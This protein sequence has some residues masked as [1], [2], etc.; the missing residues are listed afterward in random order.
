V[1]AAPRAAAARRAACQRLDAPRLPGFARARPA[2]LV[3]SAGVLV[4]LRNLSIIFWVRRR[5]AVLGSH[6]PDCRPGE[7][8]V[9]MLDVS[10]AVDDLR[11]L[12]SGLG[13]NNFPF[14]L[15]IADGRTE[16]V[17]SGSI[18]P[19]GDGQQNKSENK[20]RWLFRWL[21]AQHHRGG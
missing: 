11:P 16:T 21:L 15:Q 2:G 10:P 1:R 12:A 4:G 14:H 5:F 3:T 13:L 17:V 7:N 20:T 8:G 18:T 6:A 19:T 9:S